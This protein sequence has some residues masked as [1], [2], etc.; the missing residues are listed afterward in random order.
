MK[1]ELTTTP[2]VI[3]EIPVN[4][5]KRRLKKNLGIQTAVYGLTK[6]TY[7]G[8]KWTTPELKD[9]LYFN[10]DWG[11]VIERLR[12][13]D[14]VPSQ[15]LL[16]RY[17]SPLIVMKM[18]LLKYHDKL[19]YTNK[20][21][22]EKYTTIELDEELHSGEDY[23]IVNSV[24]PD[25]EYNLDVWISRTLWDYNSSKWKTVILDEYSTAR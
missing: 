16:P 17:E 23:I 21:R 19:T 20:G 11:K 18:Y 2:K 8:T 12:D 5:F 7:N 6:L 14:K 13:K 3:A 15:E 9:I 24:I 25:A 10:Q 4:E 22:S 1:I